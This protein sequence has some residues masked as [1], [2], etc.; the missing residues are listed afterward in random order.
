M[1]RTIQASGRW[2]RRLRQQE[3][4]LPQVDAIEIYQEEFGESDIA[5]GVVRDFYRHWRALTGSRDMPMM[6]EV[7]AVTIPRHVLPY[8]CVVD[9]TQDGRFKYRVAGTKLVEGCGMEITGRFVDEIAGTDGIERRLRRLLRTRKPYHCIV[10]L[11]WST[12][13][14]KHY[15]SVVCPLADP[16]TEAVGRMIGAGWFD[17]P[18]DS[19]PLAA[20]APKA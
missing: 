15:E 6:S 20:L 5:C 12:M 11:T 9:V 18:L 16:R 13:T 2:V 7:D 3:V 8:I 1:S 17:I 10:P 4:M 19:G 14:Y